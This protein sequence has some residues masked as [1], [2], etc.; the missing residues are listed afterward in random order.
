M[1]SAT[2]G[3]GGTLVVSRQRGASRGR[4][5]KP[6]RASRIRAGMN[7]SALQ[8]TWERI[9]V[10]A[11]DRLRDPLLLV[12]RLTWGWMFFATGKGKLANLAGTAEFFH[13]LGIPLPMF[14]ALFVGGLE[15][16]GGVLLLLGLMGR[17][18]ALLLAGNMLVAYL[19]A[20]RGGFQSLRA[21]TEAAPYPFLM[22]ALLVLAFG[23]GR[24]S[25]DALLWR[26][27]AAGVAAAA[28][29][30]TATGGQA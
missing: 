6:R 18:I 4:G 19:T 13:S 3:C 20:D 8:E 5:Q 28:G 14:N 10:R 11:L 21:F 23:P 24:W 1:T 17:P 27:P 29:C 26:K 30:R 2:L 22:A 7:M 16:A 25:L 12:V 9:K 15:C